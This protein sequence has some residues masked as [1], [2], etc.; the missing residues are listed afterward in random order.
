MELKKGIFWVGADLQYEGLQCN[1]YL[2]VDGDE[3]ILIDPGSV[4]DFKYVFKNVTEIISLDK[5]KYVVLHHQDPDLCS[6]VTLFEEKGARFKVITH[7]RTHLLTNYYGIK[8]EYYL[9]DENNFSIR[10]KSGRELKFIPTPYLHFSGAIATYDP[11]SKILFSSDLFGGILSEWKLYADESYIESMKAFHE[12]YM[13]SN[14]ILSSVMK[15]FLTMDIDMIAPQHGCIIKE[16]VKEHMIAL[17]DLDCG[18]FM[19]HIKSELAKNGGLKHILGFVLKRYASIFGGAELLEV[20]GKLDMNIDENTF[21]VI[22]YNYRSSEIWNLLFETILDKKG[23]HWLIII[24]PLVEKLAK[25]YD[26]EKPRLFESNIKS[27]E[28]KLYL[29]HNEI[30]QLKEMNETLKTDVKAIEEKLTICP[31]TRLYNKEFYNSYMRNLDL[32]QGV[33][34]LIVLTLDNWD[35]I[36]NKFGYDE[37]NVILSNIAYIIKNELDNNSLAFRLDGSYFALYLA[38]KNKEEAVAIAE[39]IRNQVAQSTVFIEQTTLS[40]GVIST[41]EY[42]DSTESTDRKSFLNNK[43]F[44]R[45]KH[46]RKNGMNRVCSLSEAEDNIVKKYKIA[47]ADTDKIHIEVL[48]RYFESVDFEVYIAIDGD[49]LLSIINET[50]PDI[51]VSEVMLQKSDVFLVREKALQNS[52]TKNIPFILVSHLKN[53]DSVSR[54]INL[55]IC[56][57]LRKPYIMKELLGIV[58]LSLKGGKI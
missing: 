34:S 22:D 8:S 6:S 47:I 4:L 30:A 9:V 56:N 36:I 25:E 42:D 46:A 21:E 53:E 33:N 15:M 38:G 29:Y 58:D 48:K 55:G 16:N 12:H 43:A 49:E 37:V 39:K 54:A 3:A 50:M 51:V 1:P 45:V 28:E 2:I 14:D 32:K 24:E 40:L 31:V 35:H 13:P 57:Y 27:S 19:N 44:I 5:I 26:I 52:Y 10:L 20:I 23:I 11:S 41:D 17:R 18:M 7:W